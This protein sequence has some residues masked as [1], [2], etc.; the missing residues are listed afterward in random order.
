MFFFLF[1]ELQK[2]QED[3]QSSKLDFNGPAGDGNSNE[4]SKIKERIPSTGMI[5]EGNACF[6][7]STLQALFHVPAFAD[8]LIV[9]CARKM[10]ICGFSLV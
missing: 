9:N 6:L 1:N 8:F 10:V 5:N 4:E 7:N 3:A 2:K